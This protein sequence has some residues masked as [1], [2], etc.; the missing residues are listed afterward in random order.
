MILDA[1]DSMPG[2]VLIQG[3]ERVLIRLGFDYIL[4][5][6]F[7]GLGGDKMTVLLC[8]VTCYI[9]SWFY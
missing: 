5:G 7:V 9:V 1:A 6:I 4:I 8:I 2:R 3:Y